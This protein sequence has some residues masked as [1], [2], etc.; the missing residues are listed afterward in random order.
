MKLI[1]AIVSF[2]LGLAG[3]FAAFYL[4]HI[5]VDVL[6]EYLTIFAEFRVAWYLIAFLFSLI[7]AWLMFS[8]AMANLEIGGT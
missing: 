1:T 6:T 5:V 3:F 2:V 4:F 7:P 8:W